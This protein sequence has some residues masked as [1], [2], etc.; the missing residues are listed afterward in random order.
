MGLVVCLDCVGTVSDEA[1]VCVHCGKP[2][3]EQS[4]D[5]MGGVLTIAYAIYLVGSVP[6]VALQCL[7]AFGRFAEA[8]RAPDAMEVMIFLLWLISVSASWIALKSAAK[9]PKVHRRL[10][11]REREKSAN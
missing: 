1:E 8:G 3:M 11:V 2:L 6:F 4:T 10:V 7:R 9:G 5:I